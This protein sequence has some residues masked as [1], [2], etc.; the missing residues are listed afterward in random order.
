MIKSRLSNKVEVRNK[1]LN[2][3]GIFASKGENVYENW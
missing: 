1:S 2:G 3:K